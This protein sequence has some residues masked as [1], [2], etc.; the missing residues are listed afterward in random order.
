MQDQ[1]DLANATMRNMKLPIFLKENVEHFML[2]T[3]NNLDS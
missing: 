3:Q 1:I 2:Q